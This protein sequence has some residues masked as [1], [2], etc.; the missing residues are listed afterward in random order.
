MRLDG[1]WR[2]CRE[3]IEPRGGNAGPS[4]FSP[5]SSTWFRLGL[6]F[7]F[8]FGLGLGLGFG[9]GFGFGLGLVFGFGLGLILAE[10]EHLERRGTVVEA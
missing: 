1:R 4:R 7:G 8:G 10:V 6:G 2:C 3:A 5:R 9:L